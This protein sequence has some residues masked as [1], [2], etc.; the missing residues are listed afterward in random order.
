[1]GSA[2][3]GVFDHENWSVALDTSYFFF[4]SDFQKPTQRFKANECVTP[5][6]KDPPAQPKILQTPVFGTFCVLWHFFYS[7]GV[8]K[9]KNMPACIY[10]KNAQ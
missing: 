2:R 1:M 8:K 9:K 3:W 10:G 4:P 5:F 6:E 7:N